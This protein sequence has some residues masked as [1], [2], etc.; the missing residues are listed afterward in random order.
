ME[1]EFVTTP[2]DPL[3]ISGERRI[4]EQVKCDHGCHSSR[5]VAIT[6]DKRRA[7]NV[8]GLAKTGQ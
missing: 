5:A 1:L 4:I 3:V 2:C 6:E 8:T 7:N